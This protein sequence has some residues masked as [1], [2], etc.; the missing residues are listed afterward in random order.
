VKPESI[1]NV[2]ERLSRLSPE[3]Q[4]LFELKLKKLLA[5]ESPAKRLSRRAIGNSAPLSFAQQ[6][7]WFLSQL[8]P[9]SSAYNQPKALRLAGELSLEALEKALD[10]VVARHE[11]LR[12]VITA[13]DDH[14]VQVIREPRRV[15]LPVIDLSDLAESQREREARRLLREITS[16]P[17]DLTQDLML[18]A[19]V[20]R[21]A[22]KLHIL[23]LVTHH[24]ASDGWSRS[25]LW[26][27]IA[28]LYAAFISGEAA[29]LTELPIQY[30][31]YAIWQRQTL[32]GD[33]LAAQLSY[34]KEKLADITELHLPTDRPRTS[35]QSYNGE[36]KSIL[37]PQEL[38]MKLER[39]SR[40]ENVTL[41]MTVLAAFQGLLHRYTG[42]DD[43]VVGSPIANR[44]RNEIEGL[45]GFFVNTLVLRANFSRSLTFRE[46]LAQVRETALGAYAHQDLP[47][48]K[49]VEE[50][51]P[52]RNLNHT[53]LVH[54]LFN[55]FSQE[56][57]KV[58]L[59][60]LTA[61]RVSSFNPTSKFDLT[62]YVRQHGG[63][64]RF[65]LVY[66][67]DL[68]SEL[69]MKC[70]LEQYR[71]LL[72]QIVAA[73]EKPVRAYSLV[74]PESRAL[75]PDPGAVLTEPPQPLVAGI[76]LL[77]AKQ[78]PAHPAIRQGQQTWSYDDLRRCADRLARL[79]VVSGLAPQDVVAVYGQP[80]FG[81]IAAMIAVFLSGGV[82]LP[83]DCTL[84]RQR[85]Q[86][87]LREARA[88]KLLYVGAKRDDEG[89]L[90]EEF[91]AD[92][93]FM[94]PQEGCLLGP[95]AAAVLES[96]T[97]PQVD[98]GDPAYIFFTSGTT[99]VPKGVLGCHKGLSHFLSWQRETF[100]IGPADRVSQLTGV[101]FDAVLRD[102]FLPLT[103]GATLCLRDVDDA[104]G[105]GEIV[106]WLERQQITVLHAVPSLAQSWL[107]CSYT[108]ARLQSMRW[109]FFV[110][111]PLT[112][113][114][115]RQWRTAFHNAAEIV[116]LYGPTE[117][118]LVKCF[119]RIPADPH[120]GV[121]PVGRPMPNTQALVLNDHQQLCGINE[122]GEIVLRTPFRTLGYLN[123]PEENQQRFVKNPFRDDA[124]DLIYFTGD[125][126]C[127][128]PDGTLQILGRRD[129][130]IKIH[131][132]R[133]EPAEVTAIL[134][135]H[136]LIESCVVVGKKNDRQEI[137]LAAYA[138][139]AGEEKVTAAALRSYLL[140]QLPTAMVP[141][142]FV[143]LDALP[144]TPNGKINRRAL[145]ETD[146]QG[147]APEE[148]YLAP[149]TEM[150]NIVAVIWAEV[151][152]L[153]RVGIRDN[154]FELGGHSLLATQIV[155]RIREALQVDLA[156][157]ALFEK[158]TVAGLSE[159]LATIQ[160]GGEQNQSVAGGEAGEMEEVTL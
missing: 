130:E 156:L 134:A 101:S 111:E 36:S 60:G 157:R 133:I 141:S 74:T 139:P 13:S 93:F 3:Q 154:F 128:R 37:L 76:V 96:V 14:T 136:P 25:I 113:A 1:N 40:Q 126:G 29:G 81:L 63:Q 71:Y 104:F 12:T 116:N 23:L 45:I 15:Q 54:A 18:R 138:V 20:L 50:I 131:G 75:L 26:G 61:E 56:D 153:Q 7:I 24:I 27:E 102:I 73:P 19:A 38:S 86:R 145:P 31:D 129:D 155:S 80:T 44:S 122:P 160:R 67:T 158:P 66:C 152:K 99:G 39:F 140:E 8:A 142:V 91:G 146:Q 100:A 4:A 144:L 55:M 35:N 109:V 125:A 30:A 98:G 21:L 124:Q 57:L 48:D 47:F 105:P 118:T 151:L 88:K 121:Q 53:P 89:W 159:H 28:A 103:S 52:V 82:L 42:Q 114:F 147:S 135:R 94:D 107:A 34:W 84:P 11:I 117:T 132:V 51:H 148:S 110:G 143:F 72:E 137:Y 120:P 83:L 87:M 123:C 106:R 70:L 2:A 149:R 17:F 9:D 32:A 58:E 69:R 112:D 95:K 65:D 92:I 85:L 79:L 49:L 59:P 46:L 108:K 119:Y 41:F 64:I 127:Y 6:R 77:W 16:R 90:E 5:S 68:F 33:V 97:L 150:E 10:G 115:V 43:I 62:L 22:E 78:A